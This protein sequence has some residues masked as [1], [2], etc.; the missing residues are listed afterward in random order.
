MGSSIVLRSTGRKEEGEEE[1]EEAVNTLPTATG[2]IFP[3]HHQTTYAVVKNMYSSKRSL[4]KSVVSFVVP[5]MPS[6]SPL[7]AV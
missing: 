2:G 6:V 4:G 7:F 3:C 5:P 1:D